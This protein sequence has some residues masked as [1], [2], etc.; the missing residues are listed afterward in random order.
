MSKKFDLLK[1]TMIIGV[2]KVATQFISFLL[3]PVYTI[4]LSPSDYGLADLLLTYILLL[5]PLVTI[6]LDMGAFRYMLDSRGDLQ[7]QQKVFV[8]SIQLYAVMLS[9]VVMIGVFANSVY[10]IP[11]FWLVIIVI[12]ASTLASLFLNIARG[13]GHNVKFTIASIVS[14]AV[15]L[16][17][18]LWAFFNPKVQTWHDLAAKTFVIKA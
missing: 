12:I 11:Y 13:L 1:N 5:G 9:C 7:E 15:L 4:Y 14:G 18:Y 6:Q 3:L 16:L 8:S 10:R 2:G 17:G